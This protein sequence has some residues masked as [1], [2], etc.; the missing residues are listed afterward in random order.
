M[1]PHFFLW[2]EPGVGA[3][4]LQGVRGT[5]EGETAEGKG[6]FAWKRWL[7]AKVCLCCWHFLISQ[8]FTKINQDRT[9]GISFVTSTI[10]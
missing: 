7:N 8:C 1:E 2:T 5:R 4:E 6:I 10:A 3:P 9:T